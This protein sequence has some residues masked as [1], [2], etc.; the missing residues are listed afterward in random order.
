MA[1]MLD[2]VLK[3]AAFKPKSTGLPSIS[4]HPNTSASGNGSKRNL[5]G[6]MI[7]VES[8]AKKLRFEE[9]TGNKIPASSQRN[10]P[11][12]RASRA[13]GGKQVR[14]GSKTRA[15]SSNSSLERKSPQN[16]LKHSPVKILQVHNP[17][18]SKESSASPTKPTANST[19]NMECLLLAAGLEV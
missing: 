18:R 8:E 13:K 10:R 3:S 4:S 19:A 12:T 9:P 14:Q 11:S 7:Q 6:E 16:P 17:G 15:P 2:G 1:K 5:T